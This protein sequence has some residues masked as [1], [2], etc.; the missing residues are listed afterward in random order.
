M[1]GTSD[2][3]KDGATLGGDYYP[4]ENTDFDRKALI[5]KTKKETSFPVIDDLVVWFEEMIA[6][7]DSIDAIDTEKFTIN[8]VSMETKFGIEAQ[9][10]GLKKLKELLTVKQSEFKRF[11]EDQ[12]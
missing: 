5:D 8:G 4:K 9:L 3:P 10:Y 2:Y 12:K 7:C 6:S 11:L 1:A